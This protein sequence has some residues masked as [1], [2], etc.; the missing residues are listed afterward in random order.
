MNSAGDVL[1]VGKIDLKNGSNASGGYIEIKGSIAMLN[2]ANKTFSLNGTPVSYS[3][4]T[5][6]GMLVSNS[7][8]EVK[9]SQDSNGVA[10]LRN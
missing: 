9:G 8:V 3:N 10:L 4:A 2:T 6:Q 5:V 1:N 7:F